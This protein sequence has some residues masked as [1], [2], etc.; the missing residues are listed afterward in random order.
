MSFFDLCGNE[1]LVALKIYE[2]F[3]DA[4]EYG[5]ILQPEV[6]LA[7]LDALQKRLDEV[8][9]M[10]SYGDLFAQQRCDTITNTMYPLVEQARALVQKYD[11]VV[12]NPPYMEPATLAQ[13]CR[14][15]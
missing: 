14:S 2:S 15:T 4:K 5:S 7:E 11:V 3:K 9:E 13:E 6:T 10:S 12:T 1:K 8:F